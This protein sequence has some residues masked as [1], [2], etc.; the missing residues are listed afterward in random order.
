[1]VQHSRRTWVRVDGRVFT[2][3]NLFRATTGGWSM[4]S[5]VR[6][7]GL[8]VHKD[9]IVMAVAEAGT[10]P[11]E[12]FS[13]LAKDPAAVLSRLPK[14]GPLSAMIVRYD[15]GPT[16]NRAYRFVNG[17]GVPMHGVA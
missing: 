16:G 4:Q 17:A 8:D 5:T 7:V 11:A 3:P 9:T 15:A 2:I 14:L 6:Y 1:M 12:I 10:Q 13:T